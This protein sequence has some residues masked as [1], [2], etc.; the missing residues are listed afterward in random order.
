MKRRLSTG[1]LAE[2]RRGQEWRKDHNGDMKRLE[3]KKQEILEK[4]RE[5]EIEV[6]QLRG[7]IKEGEREKRKSEILDSIKKVKD[8]T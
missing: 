8:R 3:Q 1:K 7:K 5:K 2:E 4:S 6:E